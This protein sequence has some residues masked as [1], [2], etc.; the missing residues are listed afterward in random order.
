VIVVPELVRAIYRELRLAAVL[1]PAIRSTLADNECEH[2]R[3]PGDPSPP[4]GCY[5]TESVSI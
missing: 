4:C 5:G 2:G 3:L 1:E